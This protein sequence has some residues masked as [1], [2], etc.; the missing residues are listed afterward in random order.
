MH[1]VSENKLLH[2]ENTLMGKGIQQE[3]I[4]KKQI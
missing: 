4:L 1:L 2:R 3:K